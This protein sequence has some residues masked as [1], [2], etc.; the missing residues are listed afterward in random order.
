[1]CSDPPASA[2]CSLPHSRKS[3]STRA[4]SGRAELCRR[5]ARERPP[6]AAP[7]PSR[8]VAGSCRSTPDQST[9]DGGWSKRKDSVLARIKNRRRPRRPVHR[10]QSKP[11][12]A[13]LIGTIAARTGDVLIGSSPQRKKNTFRFALRSSRTPS[14]PRGRPSFFG[15]SLPATLPR[16]GGVHRDVRS[17]IDAGRLRVISLRGPR[18][19]ANAQQLHIQSRQSSSAIHATFHRS[20]RVIRDNAFHRHQ[21]PAARLSRH[22]LQPR[23]TRYKTRPAKARSASPIHSQPRS[24][25]AESLRSASPSVA[26]STPPAAAAASC[27]NCL[28]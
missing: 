16:T 25:R 26:D 11:A 24:R 14:L 22:H 2:I 12:S 3:N 13:A 15:A 20:K 23:P 7:S 21:R 27:R 9:A 6:A 1:M 8:T 17:Q 19:L 5:R 10:R 18:R 4:S 28:L